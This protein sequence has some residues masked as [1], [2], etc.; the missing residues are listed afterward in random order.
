MVCHGTAYVVSRC[1]WSSEAVSV[2]RFRSPGAGMCWCH[3]N[4]TA[5]QV[6]WRTCSGHM[7]HWKNVLASFGFLQL[8][9]NAR[10]QHPQANSATCLTLICTYEI[11]LKYIAGSRSKQKNAKLCHAASNVSCIWSEH[12]LWSTSQPLP[13]LTSLLQL[14]PLS[15]CCLSQPRWDEAAMDV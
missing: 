5:T 7:A 15:K 6:T 14:L 1:V 3:A 9:C 8:L 13:S 10:S 2:Q 12:S 11:V 4:H